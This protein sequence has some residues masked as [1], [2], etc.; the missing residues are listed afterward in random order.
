MGNIKNKFAKLFF[1][2]DLA[3]QTQDINSLKGELEEL[4]SYVKGEKEIALLES[5]KKLVQK[6][7]VE[8][9]SIKAELSQNHNENKLQDDKLIRL[10]SVTKGL[11]K[12]VN[13]ISTKHQSSA[14]PTPDYSYLMLE[15]RYRGPEEEIT[16][17]LEIYPAYFNNSDKAVLE[18]GSGRGELQ[19]LFK[20]A[21]IKSYGVELDGAMVEHSREKNLEIIEE[22]GL[23]HLVSLQDKSLG[24]LIAVQVIEH[25]SKKQLEDLF[26]LCAKKVE[27]KVIFE[28]INTTSLSAL[29]HN[30]F[31]DPTHVLPIHPETIAYMME[32]AGL[33]V[34]AIN[35][36]SPFPKEASLQEIQIEGFYTPRWQAS[37]ETLNH[38]IRQLNNL[39]YAPQDYF[40]VANSK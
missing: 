21:G 18:I 13:Q 30:Y 38:N 8:V 17:R 32:L 26:S 20:N 24:G 34:E 25:L 37:L 19:T 6:I 4:R 39:L 28:T 15:N 36:L 7:D 29:C 10:D 2:V 23:K 11:E 1:G 27:G 12:I 33:E 22:D 9:N 16:E 40:V 14:E 35:K 5:E 31:R 3:K